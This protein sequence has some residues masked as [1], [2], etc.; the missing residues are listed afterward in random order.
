VTSAL[1]QNPIILVPTRL[2]ATRLP[3]KPLAEIAGEPMIVHVW[4]R[5]VAAEIGPVVVA[6]GDR[7]IVDVV[8]RQGGR[9]VLTDPELPTGSDRIHAALG[10]LDPQG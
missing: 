5:A 4:R 3:N 6:S 7:E 10:A 2:A 1:P 9:A 8:E